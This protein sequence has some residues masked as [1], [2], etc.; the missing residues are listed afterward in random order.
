MVSLGFNGK[1]GLTREE[2]DYFLDVLQDTLDNGES[3]LLD[4]VSDDS[5]Q[6]FNLKWDEV[7]F[8]KQLAA[9]QEETQQLNYTKF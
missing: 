2:A 6:T 1:K 8:Q 5:I 9:R 3:D 7:E 4:F